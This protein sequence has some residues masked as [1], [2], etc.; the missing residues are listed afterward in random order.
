MD[1]PKVQY[2]LFK[3]HIKLVKEV[4]ENELDEDNRNYVNSMRKQI[5]L[6]LKEGFD[7]ENYETEFPAS[8]LHYNL[9]HFFKIIVSILT[10][11]YIFDIEFN[12]ITF[13]VSA[14]VTVYYVR[15]RLRISPV[16]FEYVMGYANSFLL[17][18][19]KEQD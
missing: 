17:K 7:L 15:K 9:G 11:I 19:K 8:C 10:I 18:R 16:W 12:W 13:V 5:K 3:S 1:Y 6:E 14:M 2:S 4:N